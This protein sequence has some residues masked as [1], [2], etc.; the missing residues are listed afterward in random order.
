MKSLQ[1]KPIPLEPNWLHTAVCFSPS[2]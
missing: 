1:S 2:L